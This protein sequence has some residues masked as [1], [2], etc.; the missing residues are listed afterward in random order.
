VT[1]CSHS[2]EP[3]CGKLI[4]HPNFIL[5]VAGESAR[6]ISR[7]SS[8]ETARAYRQLAEGEAAVRTKAVAVCDELAAIYK[9][10][11]DRQLALDMLRLK[12]DVYNGR[13]P[14]GDTC[15]QLKPYLPDDAWG[16]LVCLA[17]EIAG[18]HQL[19]TE[20]PNLYQQEIDSAHEKLRSLFD[21]ENLQKALKGA[22]QVLFR[23]L[24]SL[25]HLGT[26]F[27]SKKR[28][29]LESTFLLYYARCVLKPSPLSFFTPIS[30]GSWRAE[31]AGAGLELGFPAWNLRTRFALNRGAL[32]QVLAPVFLRPDLLGMDWPVSLN[33]TLEQKDGAV[34]LTRINDRA[35]GM[36]LLGV[37]TSRV[38]LK[39]TDLLNA[40]IDAVSSSP[41]G[42][43]S[44]AQLANQLGA[45]L[46][47][48]EQARL[49][50]YLQSLVK[51]KLLIAVNNYEEQGDLLDWACQ[52]TSKFDSDAGRICALKVQEIRDVFGRI[53][54]AGPDEV[55]ILTGNIEGQL[56]DL[57]SITIGPDESLIENSIHQD[58][59]IGSSPPSLAISELDALQGDLNSF[60]SLC[61]LF[62]A[63]VAIQAW[64]VNE[65]KDVAG[66]GARL[67]HP[68]QFLS[69]ANARMTHQLTSSD[70]GIAG[71]FTRLGAV[72]GNDPLVKVQKDLLR[73]LDLHI[74]ERIQSGET[75]IVV[76]ARVL[77][78]VIGEIPQAL[79]KRTVSQSIYGQLFRK[80]DGTVGFV[81]NQ[82]YPGNSRMM[83]RFLD[84]DEE[85][86]VPIRDYLGE[87]SQGARYAEIPGVFGFNANLH[88]RLARAELSIPPYEPSRHAAEKL[89]IDELFLAHDEGSDTL[90]LETASGERIDA[91]FMGLMHPQFFPETHKWL[92]IMSARAATH[93]RVGRRLRSRLVPDAHGIVRMPR[94][95]IGQLVMSRAMTIV[96]ENALIDEGKSEG[97]FF[98]AVQDWRRVAGIP[99]RVFARLFPDMKTVTKT[100]QIKPFYLDF[101]DAMLVRL[102]R[103]GL[104][105]NKIL[106]AEFAEVLPDPADSFVTVAGQPHVS[107]LQFEIARRGE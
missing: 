8:G 99:E 13:P 81:L 10:I 50:Q 16:G 29:S 18:F 106:S 90:H 49:L 34:T 53:S 93:W 25:F 27:A 15:Q 97:E 14:R 30:L 74:L 11:T 6:G 66:S 38:S 39:A 75:D 47:Q 4:F 57:A 37:Q 71:M 23:E 2:P 80:A 100:S 36:I 26:E 89:P 62:D 33:P 28:R 102:F 19:R 69:L 9:K 56:K 24:K 46:G 83:S 31:A 70:E 79:C 88:P 68:G 85:I 72:T 55:A 96:S 22:N 44:I 87:I 82:V 94:V 52:V 54:D 12:R 35:K 59:F 21:G 101:S 67:A 98:F 1:L 3:G 78:E 5:R 107:E 91:Y 45:G 51:Q 17:D 86:L 92:D 84:E 58:C 95:S 60:L 65:F 48:V 73:K 20:L 64:L 104:R 42:L 7:I 32:L 40:V 105:K 43:S 41:G 77:A 76:D 63:N 61:V 103:R